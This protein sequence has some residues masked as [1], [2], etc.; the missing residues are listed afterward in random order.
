MGMDLFWF[1]QEARTKTALR[2]ESQQT[3][4]KEFLD[5]EEIRLLADHADLVTEQRNLHP[6]MLDANTWQGRSRFNL[7]NGQH[8]ELVLGGL[9]P[10]DFDRVHQSP[11]LCLKELAVDGRGFLTT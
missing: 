6:G 5:F 2:R 8:N 4:R 10:G 1:K 11:I 3:C 9:A 7:P